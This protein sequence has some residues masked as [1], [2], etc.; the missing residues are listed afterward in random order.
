MKFSITSRI[1]VIKI[2]GAFHCLLMVLFPFI[3]CGCSFPCDKPAKSEI[4]ET[5]L[6][7]FAEINIPFLGIRSPV[8]IKTKENIK[9]VKVVIHISK[10]FSGSMDKEEIINKFTIAKTALTITSRLQQ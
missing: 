1:P 10:D 7:A 2:A 6:L 5:Y 3:S 8:M 4:I 9:Y